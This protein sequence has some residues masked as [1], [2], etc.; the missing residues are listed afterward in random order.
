MASVIEQPVRRAVMPR[1]TFDLP[2]YGGLTLTSLRS[3]NS[4]EES[5]GPGAVPWVLDGRNRTETLTSWQPL[6]RGEWF[7]QSLLSKQ[8]NRAAV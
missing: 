4:G 6:A 1:R 3:K 8:M 5:L 2:A 7:L